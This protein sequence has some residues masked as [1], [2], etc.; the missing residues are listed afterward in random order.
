MVFGFMYLLLDSKQPRLAMSTGSVTM[1]PGPGTGG[2][3]EIDDKGTMEGTDGKQVERQNREEE[4]R[5]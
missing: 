1:S 3:C 5:R 2:H 4:G